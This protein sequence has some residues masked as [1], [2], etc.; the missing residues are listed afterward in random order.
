MALVVLAP[1][2]RYIEMNKSR[3]GCSISAEFNWFSIMSNVRE[4]IGL[5]SSIIREVIYPAK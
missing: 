4:V 2:H 3:M 1:N 5:Y